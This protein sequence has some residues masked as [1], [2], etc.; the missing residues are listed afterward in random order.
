M[1]IYTEL[2]RTY[3]KKYFFGLKYPQPFAIH[4]DIF[5]SRKRFYKRAKKQKSSFLNSGYL[6]FH[7]SASLYSLE[8]Q[9]HICNPQ[10]TSY[11]EEEAP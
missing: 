7:T 8:F 1:R 4:P 10:Y 2:R 11:Y 5:R 6:Q 9:R 3:Q